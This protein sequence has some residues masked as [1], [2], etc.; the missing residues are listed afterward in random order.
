MLIGALSAILILLRIHLASS[1]EQPRITPIQSRI[2]LKAGKQ[3]SFTCILEQGSLPVDFEWLK[4][5][6]VIRSSSNA[7]IEKNQRTSSLLLHSTKIS[8][9]GN[10]SCKVSNSFGSDMS[11]SQLIVEGPPQ[12]LSKPQDIRVGPKE[13]FTITCSGIG[14]PSPTVVWKRQLDSSWKDLFDLS[15]V[16]ARISPTEMSGY[17]LMKER[18]EGKYGCEISNGINPSL[19]TEF[20]IQV[21]GKIV[22]LSPMR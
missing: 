4:G 11:T 16:F 12:W 1:N 21:S 2:V 3:A 6:N 10:Y 9:S 13:R 22:A 20:Q 18:D 8:D 15:T 7:V 14:H 19:W 5:N 17:Q